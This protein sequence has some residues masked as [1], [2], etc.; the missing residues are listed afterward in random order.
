METLQNFNQELS[1]ICLPNPDS[2]LELRSLLAGEF[3]LM[4]K[5]LTPPQR[6]KNKRFM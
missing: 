6:R 1:A 4:G 2:C 3:L 5:K